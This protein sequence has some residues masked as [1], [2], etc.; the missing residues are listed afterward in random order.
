MSPTGLGVRNAF[1]FIAHEFLSP[2][3][4]YVDAGSLG[5]EMIKAMGC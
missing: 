5:F 3:T 2:P 1:H 4:P